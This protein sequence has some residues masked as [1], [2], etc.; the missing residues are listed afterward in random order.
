MIVPQIL[1]VVAYCVHV[2]MCEKQGASIDGFAEI[3]AFTCMVV[4]LTMNSYFREMH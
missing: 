1:F 2:F 3:G 4:Y